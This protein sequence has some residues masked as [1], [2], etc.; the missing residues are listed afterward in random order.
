MLRPVVKLCCTLLL[1][2]SPAAFAQ[3][4]TISTVAG[5]A[6]PTTP[7][8]AV[9]TA[10]GQPHKVTAAGSNLYFSSGNS[11]FKLDSGGTL[12]LIAGNSRAGFAGDGGPAVNAQLNSPQGIA[13]DSAGNIYIADSL[14]NRVRMVDPSG[15]I[16]TFAG[17]GSISIPG[18]WGDTGPAT[19]ANLH[20][21]VAVA[22][23]SAGNVY[24]CAAS[25]H[26][27]RKVA[28]DGTISL[29]AG[30]GY[31]GYY[32]D[33]GAA[34]LA[35]LRSPEDI[36]TG[37]DNSLF[38]ADTGN[39]VIRKVGKDGVISTVSGSGG[40][41]IGGDGV[42]IKIPMISPFGVAVNSG[43]DIFVAEVGSNRIRKI[44]S[45]GNITTAVGDGMQGFAGDGA[46]PAT[47]R[48]SLPTSVAVDAGGN[49]Y[50]ADSLNYRVRKLAGSTVST[51]AGNGGISR[52][53][54]GGAATSAQLNTPLGV[55]VDSAGNIYIADT[56]NNVVRRVA[57]N[58]IISV[59][60]G[61]GT[62]GS[63]GDGGAATSAQL[64]GPQGVAVDAS[65]SVY[66]ADTQNNRVRKVGGGT[67]STIA[68]T[69]TGGFAGDGGA[70]TAAQ[71]KA[72]FSVAVDTAG[73]V[74]I[75]EF[76]NNRVR[77]V[78]VNGT[79]ST[80]AGTGVSGYGGDGGSA[81]S[82]L[83][84]GPQGVAVDA[85]GNVYI[86]DT[87]NNRVRR[88]TPA[89][90]IGTLAGNGVAGYDADGGQAGA[91]QVGNPTG[92]AADSF[93]NVYI[94]D[95]SSRVRKVF[96]SGIIATIAG[97]GQ[98]GYSG[99]GGAAGLAQL[100]GP[101]AVAVN[102]AGNVYLADTNNNSVRLLQVG[103]FGISLSA[104]VNSA[105]NLS[106]PI[107]PGEVVVLYGTGLG[108]ADLT[109]Y[110]ADANGKVPTSLA[111]TSV[112]FNGAP[113]PVLY[114]SANQ[115]A[116]VVP[117]AL[118][119][120]SQAQIFAQYQGQTSA[121]FTA[122][123][124]TAIPALFT[125]GSG[126]GQAAA[127]NTVDGGL[128]GAAHPAKPGEFIS[129]YLTGAGQTDPAGKDG[130]P[131]ADPLPK[132][133]L[134]VTATVAGIATTVQFAGGAPNLVAGVIQVNVRIPTGIASLTAAPLP[135]PVEVQVG[136]SR[137]QPN[138]TIYLATN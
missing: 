111:G 15:M 112:L 63:S 95:G 99:D 71:L 61:T 18:F 73:N 135:V 52:S 44:D 16:T 97:N 74:Y 67:I 68:G 50:F 42:A 35:G 84:N 11:V 77:K 90:A 124:A 30:T 25:D 5:G 118:D 109:Q 72:P 45:K 117:Y 113:A 96:T 7:A 54:D 13:L 69:G 134:S 58:G 80:L 21:P 137:T 105:S 31:A 41:G 78:A 43:G 119:G 102:S 38:I 101:S 107:A 75:A 19:D 89:G 136:T 131:N 93:G 126:T 133:L 86:A 70:A 85:A 40:Q 26:A 83:L 132:P 46:A 22:V 65:G 9:N 87:A 14:N 130:V 82:A 60:A 29:F 79:I 20:I 1:G 123:V 51:I 98:R 17:N 128:N 47:A 108:P 32:G 4:Y 36:S 104:I 62:A 6:P 94:S 37:P 28:L 64:S 48:L 12:T 114:T 33:T 122:S 100:N 24:I 120:S 127:I 106:G 110:Q 81:T 66:I 57:S 27:I 121:A 3:Q 138:V 55:A 125:L 34:G 115:V 92:V 56:F 116:A 129:L 10:I 59:F 39:A 103:G 76:S 88:V 23:D 53:G 91:T 8:S 49:L 2:S